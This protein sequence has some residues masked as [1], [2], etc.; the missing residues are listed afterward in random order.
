MLGGDWL[1]NAAMFRGLPSNRPSL[2]SFLP[3]RKWEDRTVR[4]DSSSKWAGR[5]NLGCLRTQ[6][7]ATLFGD[8]PLS[9]KRGWPPPKHLNRST[10]LLTPIRV[11]RSAFYGTDLE[12]V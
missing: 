1:I 8:T 3:V 10:P 12:K 9:Y 2:S 4:I 11:H 5:A 6:E 7:A